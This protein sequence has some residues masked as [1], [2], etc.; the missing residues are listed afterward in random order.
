MAKRPA[1]PT[2]VFVGSRVRFFRLMKNW[3]QT[4]LAGHLDLTFQQVQK[5]ER[6]SNR[7][8][9][10]R[11]SKIAQLLDKPVT[12]FYPAGAKPDDEDSQVFKMVD[13]PQALRL[14]LAFNAMESST[15]RAALTKLAEEIAGTPPVRKRRA[16]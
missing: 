16:A 4:D 6:G 14:L 2:D 15:A 1:D 5:Y 10:G 3:S 8:G 11:L 9:A 7:I 12:A 13:T